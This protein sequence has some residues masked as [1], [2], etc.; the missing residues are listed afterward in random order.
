MQPISTQSRSAR[1]T[2]RTRPAAVTAVALAALA[3]GWPQSVPAFAVPAGHAP[4][5]VTE[6]GITGSR[7]PVTAAGGLV[8][9]GAV[10]K[11]QARLSGPLHIRVYL[12]GRDPAGLRRLA[13]AVS[14]PGSPSY[15]HFLTHA[16]FA[17][18]FGPTARQRARVTSWLRGC[19]FKVARPNPHFVGA[20]GGQ[21]AVRCAVRARMHVFR[22]HRITFLAPAGRLTIPS[23]V[24]SDVLSITGLS[25]LRPRVRPASPH[26]L[27]VTAASTATCSSY[28]GANPASALPAAYG[29]IQPWHVCGYL[30]S[31]LRSAYGVTGTG[32][33]GTGARVAIVDAFASTTMASDVQTYASLHG[34]QGWAPG[35]LTQQV[36]AGLPPQPPN[37]DTEEIMDVEA[38]HAIAPSADVVYVASAGNDDSSFLDALSR[39]TDG[40][41]ADIVSGSWVLGADTGVPAA[42][43]LAYEQVFLEG[44]VEGIGF[45]FA[46]GDTGSQAASAD[47]T[48]PLETATQYPASDPWAT[49]VGGTSLAIGASGQYQWETGWETDYAQLS[50]DGTSWVNPPGSFADGAGG[51]PS[52]EFPRPWYQFATVPSGSFTIGGV[53]RRV[54]PDVAMDADPVTGMLIGQT[55]TLPT[56][57][58]YVQ[59]ASGGT[60]LATPLFAGIEALA[61]Q[62]AGR[63]LGF[64]NPVIYLAKAAG[65]FRDVTDSPTGTAPLAAVHTLLSVSATGQLT[66]TDVLATLGRS[67]DTGL[68][69]APGYDDVTGVGSP[70][71]GYLTFVRPARILR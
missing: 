20:S 29:A 35:Q 12:A 3:L 50:A 44:T 1:L 15:H 43:V 55:F 36:P 69:C 56:T 47:G 34:E 30:P 65:A 53:A 45:L 52:G 37:W 57:S 27:R 24:A 6:H 59:F 68:T 28:F 62:N 14:A 2:R 18:K 61:E 38:V 58:V 4:A 66:V 17:A 63:P 21:A 67:G 51:G 26:P 10:D 16:Q 9:A 64:A 60:S 49:G 39:I 31:Q 41:L 54:V 71:G 70:A 11:G 42:T 46:S 25:T 13:R 40:H 32:L 8:P 33:T 5:A 19:G 23:R 22:W 48:G 7:V